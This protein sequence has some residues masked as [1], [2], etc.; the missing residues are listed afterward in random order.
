MVKTAYTNKCKWLILGEAKTCGRTCKGQYCAMHNYRQKNVQKAP[1]P[2]RKCGRGVLCDYRLCYWCGGEKLR[3]KLAYK[4][5]KARRDY[6]GVLYELVNGPIKLKK[7]KRKSPRS[8]HEKAKTKIQQKMER[9]W[10][11]VHLELE[12]LPYCKR[13]ERHAKGLIC[14]EHENC[15]QE[16]ICATCLKKENKIQQLTPD[17][18]EYRWKKNWT[19]EIEKEHKQFALDPISEEEEEETTYILNEKEFT[20]ITEEVINAAYEAMKTGLNG[21]IITQNGK[22]GVKEALKRIE[23]TIQKEIEAALNY[24]GEGLESAESV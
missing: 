6:E 20:A 16:G 1:V 11:D 10:K 3:K 19:E 12:G 14:N 24:T 17:V 18:S 9:G 13:E 4:E 5:K 23:E 15:E 7:K 2:C 21:T 22:K 8:E